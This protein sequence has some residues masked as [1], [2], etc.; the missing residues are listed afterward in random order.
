MLYTK[1]RQQGV[2]DIAQ[3]KL[4]ILET[5]GSLTLELFTEDQQNEFKESL[6]RIEAKLS[7]LLQNSS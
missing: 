2:V 6:A 5:N 4:A 1:L 3:V 7:Q